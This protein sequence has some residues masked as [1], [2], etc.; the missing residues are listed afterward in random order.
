MQSLHLI[1][2][3]RFVHL[4]CPLHGSS[5]ASN[6]GSFYPACWL[7]PHL[8]RSP[9]KTRVVKCCWFLRRA[10]ILIWVSGFKMFITAASGVRTPKTYMRW[11]QVR[12]FYSLIF[13]WT[14][15]VLCQDLGEGFVTVLRLQSWSMG[16]LLKTPPI[17]PTASISFTVDA[18]WIPHL[19]C[20]VS[21]NKHPGLQK[22]SQYVP[23]QQRGFSGD[24]KW[25]E[26]LTLSTGC[27]GGGG[28]K[29]AENTLQ[30]SGVEWRKRGETCGVHYLQNGRMLWR[31]KHW[32]DGA[33]REH[34]TAVWG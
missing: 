23:S 26:K 19:L 28:W 31:T 1:A 11:F 22:L 14:P 12:T 5:K 25:E 29:S 34:L 13:H 20:A 16:H 8:V 4:V 15:N 9:Y 27:S 7:G 24:G 3:V 2:G 30:R 17:S 21:L 33:L 10:Y 18:V 32:A 6:P